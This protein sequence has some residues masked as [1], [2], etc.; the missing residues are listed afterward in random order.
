M[1]RLRSGASSLALVTL[2]RQLAAWKMPLFDCQLYSDHTA[3]LGARPWQ[4]ASF[5]TMLSTA[6]GLPTRRGKWTLEIDPV[7]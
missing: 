4:R 2:I 6:V 5:L 7:L 3:R 1:F